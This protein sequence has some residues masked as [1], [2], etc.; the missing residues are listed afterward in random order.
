M[1][2]GL[3]NKEAME[4]P[5]LPASMAWAAP[6]SVLQAAVRY[7]LA[8]RWGCLT[9]QQGEYE[10]IRLSPFIEAPLYYFFADVCFY[11]NGEE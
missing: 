5:S 11:V 8:A 7:Y 10:D 6:P 9:R 3:P 1:G 2:N 4:V